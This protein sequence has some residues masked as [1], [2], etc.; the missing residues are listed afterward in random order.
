MSPFIWKLNNFTIINTTHLLSRLLHQ[1]SLE[2]T[3][4]FLT[5]HA[6]TIPMIYKSQTC[7]GSRL[8]TI[9]NN[10][11]NIFFHFMVIF[12]NFCF[13]AT[14]LYFCTGSIQMLCLSKY[15]SILSVKD[16]TKFIS[17]LIYLM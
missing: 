6:S 10:K 12:P 7:H 9:T 5:Q 14:Y 13:L 2:S 17:H 15:V 16:Q 8:Y 3:P 11:H 1:K 4:L